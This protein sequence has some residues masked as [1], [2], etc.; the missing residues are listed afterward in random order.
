MDLAVTF[1]RRTGGTLEHPP[2]RLEAHHVSTLLSA[3]VVAAMLGCLLLI[4]LG[5]P[6][7]WLIVVL[8]FG[9]MLAGSL[10]WP[11]GLTVAGVALV[12]ELAEFLVLGGFGRRFG[13]SAKAFWGAVL[14][15]MAGLFVGVPIP[16]VGPI[17]TG[18]LGTFLG[19]G[20]VTYLET[21]SLERSAWVGWGVLLARSVS[22]A[23]KVGVA[24]G[25]VISVATAL[26][27]RG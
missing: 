1:V 9:L 23:L 5:L 7:L 4:P 20:L 24:L 12:T 25:V 14:G 26:F 19:A 16:V 6:G 11:F 3:F 21:R 8:T 15:G 17:V 18:F 27:M 2:V 22:V 13:G 10:S